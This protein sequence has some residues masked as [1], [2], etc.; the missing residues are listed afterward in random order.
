MDFGANC[1]TITLWECQHRRQA[2]TLEYMQR[3]CS[4]S[5]ATTRRTRFTRNRRIML[6]TLKATMEVEYQTLIALIRAQKPGAKT[7]I[8]IFLKRALQRH[9]MV[10]IAVVRVR[11]RT[12]VK[13]APRKRRC[14]FTR[15][16]WWPIIGVTRNDR[17]QYCLSLNCHNLNTRLRRRLNPTPPLRNM[18]LSVNLHHGAQHLY[19]HPRTT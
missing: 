16:F 19:E 1:Q 14:V 17:N 10:V 13:T 3:P 5:R 4:R 8:S 7:G 15:F 9:K 11:V 12:T 6:A 2:K 18:L